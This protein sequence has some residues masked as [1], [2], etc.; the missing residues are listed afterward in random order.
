MTSS[1]LVSTCP[2][3][4]MPVRPS[5]MASDRGIV[6]QLPVSSCQLPAERNGELNAS[7]LP[8]CNNPLA[9]LAKTFHSEA[10]FVAG[11]QID[12]RL[13]PVADARRR[14]GGNHVARLQAHE[15]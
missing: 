7:E 8:I 13:L 5:R 4:R 10:D 12:G 3:P 11:T 6:I 14:T 2:G 9:L 1:G 15:A